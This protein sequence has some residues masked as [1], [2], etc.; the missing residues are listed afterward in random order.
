MISNSFGRL[1][2]EELLR[3]PN[4][5]TRPHQGAPSL[6]N[7]VAKLQGGPQLPQLCNFGRWCP[8]G[9]WTTRGGNGSRPEVTSR[10]VDPRH[11]TI[12]R[13]V[14]SLIPIGYVINRV[15]LKKGLCAPDSQRP[16]SSPVRA[17]R[18]GYPPDESCKVAELRPR[19]LPQLWIGMPRH[20]AGRRGFP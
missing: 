18:A 5:K 10:P 3:C 9:R 16:A 20:V 6:R 11:T 7:E 13:C 12:T 15:K 2:L 4:Q 1:G 8:C 19:Q 14:S 17:V